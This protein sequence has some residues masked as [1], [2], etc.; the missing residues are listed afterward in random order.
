M[1]TIFINQRPLIFGVKP[2]VVAD[3]SRHLKAVY[4]GNAAQLYHYAQ[5]LAAEYCAYTAITVLGDAD[6]LLDIFTQ[7]YTLQP[8][9]GGVVRNIEGNILLIFRR[10]YWDLQRYRNKTQTLCQR[11]DSR[12]LG[13]ES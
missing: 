7:F 2:L 5:L 4:A 9:A 6:E 12:I 3:E 13:C 8:A 10:G 1:V 11:R